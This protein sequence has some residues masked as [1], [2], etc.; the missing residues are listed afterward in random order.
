MTEEECLVRCG[1]RTRNL[2]VRSSWFYIVRG[3]SWAWQVFLERWNSDDLVQ[4]P[5]VRGCPSRG[6]LRKSWEEEDTE[7][8]V[9]W[10]E[11][12]KS[13]SLAPEL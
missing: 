2:D 12:D 3:V 1:P 4:S 7:D 5:Q 6:C 8:G 11:R 13:V 9:P 10:Q